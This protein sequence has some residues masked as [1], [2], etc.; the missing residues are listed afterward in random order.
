MKR[1]LPWLFCWVTLII[2][3][4]SC[5]KDKVIVKP[6]VTNNQ[7]TLGLYQ[8]GADSGRRVFIPITKV[9]TQTVNYLSVFDTGS[10][11][12]TID[13][14]DIIPASMITNSGFNFTGESVIVNGITITSQQSVISFGNNTGLT[15]EYGNLAYASITIGDQNGNTSAK[16]VPIFL[17]Y[18][19]VNSGKAVTLTHTLD[20]FGVEPGSSS[21]NAAINSPLNYFNNNSA[22]T[23]GFRLAALKSN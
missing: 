21:A 5:S 7:V 6:V 11:G 3:A 8:Y 15:K 22:V 17:Y 16:R 10:A 18:K 20:I 4:E 23:N 13:A 19:V 2:L 14:H 9:G 12:M 1:N